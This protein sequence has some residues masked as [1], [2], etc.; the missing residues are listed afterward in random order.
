M[1]LRPAPLIG[2]DAEPIDL[3]DE[4]QFAA[5]EATLNLR[6]WSTAPSDDKARAHAAY[7]AALDREEQAALVLGERLR[8]GN[9]LRRHITGGD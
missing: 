1:S 7:L 2:F 5:T 8:L 9:V 6:I 3:W 4:W